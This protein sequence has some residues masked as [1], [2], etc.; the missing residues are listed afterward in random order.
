[1]VQARGRSGRA[2][3]LAGL[4]VWR[5]QQRRP[6]EAGP[7]GL[8]DAL[9]DSARVRELAVKARSEAREGYQRYRS[10]HDL[11]RHYLD[12]VVPLRQFVSDEMLLRY[13]GMLSSVF[14]VLTDTR[15]Q[16]LSVN[17]AINAQRDFWLADTDLQTLLAG[18]SPG[19]F[20]GDS[21][22]P[23]AGAAAAPAGH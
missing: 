6:V 18:V 11:A 14:D 21:A 17:Q 8:W 22:G 23:S 12:H 3:P 2:H 1:M 13:N 15:A 4:F 19:P 9:R 20:G 7:D 5:Q 10:R 16:A